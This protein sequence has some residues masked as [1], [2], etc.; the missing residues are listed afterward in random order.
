LKK[1]SREKYA[2]NHPK[3]EKEDKYRGAGEEKT[4]KGLHRLQEKIGP[5]RGSLCVPS[6]KGDQESENRERGSTSLPKVVKG[7]A[8]PTP[9]GDL[10]GGT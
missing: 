10:E 6:E 2:E 7:P 5:I 3:E 9:R 8:P 1:Q 4:V